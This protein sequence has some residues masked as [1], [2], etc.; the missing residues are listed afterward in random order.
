MGPAL[1]PRPKHEAAGSRRKSCVEFDTSHMM[2][3]QKAAEAR[4]HLAEVPCHQADITPRP[5]TRPPANPLGFRA[6]RL[7]DGQA[8]EHGASDGLK[9]PREGAYTSREGL[10]MS[11]L[12]GT[13]RQRTRSISGNANTNEERMKGSRPST[14]KL[15]RR[16]SSLPQLPSEAK[17]WSTVRLSVHVKDGAPKRD[18]LA[19]RVEKKKLAR[20][21]SARST[22]TSASCGNGN[23][24]KSERGLA[25][26]SRREYEA[27]RDLFERYDQNEDG[28]LDR[29]EFQAAIQIQ[30]PILAKHAVGMFGAADKNKNGEMTFVEFLTMYCPWI[31]ESTAQRCITKYGAPW[32]HP[33][34]RM[35]P[36]KHRLHHSAIL[37]HFESRR[38]VKKNLV[39]QRAD[40]SKEDI[41]EIEEVYEKWMSEGGKRSG[42]GMSFKMM[43]SHCEGVDPYT[44]GEWHHKSAAGK[45][46]TKEEFVALISSHYGDVVAATPESVAESLVRSLSAPGRGEVQLPNCVATSQSA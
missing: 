21:M 36:V 35:T 6:L 3:L 37:P 32:Q 9:N 15:Q 29:E 45:D 24:P 17:G 18:T 44:L 40:V 42:A 10:S 41:E 25:P 13:S 2:Q 46:L 8:A 23:Q 22:S 14:A 5:P 33:N 26:M 20:L 34:S 43:K 31:N 11:S 1:P 28:A 16:R 27:I 7:Q 39:P 19:G 12:Q 4:A 38:P 30:N